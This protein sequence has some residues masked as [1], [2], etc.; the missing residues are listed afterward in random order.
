M[1]VINICQLVDESSAILD[2]VP[3]PTPLSRSHVTMNKFR[4]SEDEGYKIVA[5]EI[6]DILRKIRTNSPLEEV[7][8]WIRNESYTPK[9]LEIERLTGDSLLMDQCYTNL[10][11]VEQQLDGKSSWP[12][13]DKPAQRSSQFS[14]FAR[15]KIDEPDEKIQVVLSKLFDERQAHDGQMRRPKRVLIRGWA[16][17]GKTTL[18]KKIIHDFIGGKL[19][20][21][22]FDHLLWVPLRNLKRE[23]RQTAIYNLH[24]LVRHEYF[25]HHR[26]GD[27][28]AEAVCHASES[29]KTESLFILDGLDEELQVLSGS[30]LGFLEELLNQPNVI[31]TSRPHAR[32]PSSA[33]PVDLEL[34]TIGFY[35]DQISDYLQKAFTDLKAADEF[36]SFLKKHPLMQ[37]LV[38]IPIQLDALCYTWDS[39]SAKN[40]PQAM[41]AIYKAIEESLWKKDA[42]RLEKEID[43]K[44]VMPSD[45]ESAN[46]GPI[47][48][49]ELY[50]LEGLAFTGPYQDTIDFD[51]GSRNVI[52][53]QFR[54]SGA[55]ILLDK[56]FPCLSFLRTSEPS[57]KF[58]N[59]KYHFLH[60]T[61]QEYFAA[62]YF[63][64]QWM[65][66]EPLICLE[67]KSKRKKETGPAEFLQKYKYD[68][69]YDIFWR[70]A[71]GLIDAEG[72]EEA[73]RFF[74]AI[75]EEPR[76]L[77]GPTHQRLIMHC[78]GEMV[79]RESESISSHF[80][81]GLEDHLSQ[82][83]LF[84]CEFMRG[85]PLQLAGER[86]VPEQALLKALTLASNEARRG[87]L[88]SLEP[89]PVIEPSIIH[90]ARSW[91]RDGADKR[92]EITVL[93]FL[94]KKLDLDLEAVNTIA[95]RLEH[96]DVDVQQ[97]AIQVIQNQQ[98]LSLD[99]VNIITEQLKHEDE[100]TQQTA[101]EALQNQQNLSLD[102]VNAITE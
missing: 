62:R 94:S 63:V 30:M 90:L 49:K 64:K 91:L 18:C 93:N 8:A 79:P 86:E 101:V 56:T 77:L 14:L 74:Q 89:R 66:E 53:E 48:D 69:R 76:D 37:G 60:L 35:P 28:L 16:G 23:E 97:T 11:I 19:W 102:T 34:G 26:K 25:P 44:R 83:L 5:G 87:L 73:H 98:D 85:R 17:V 47:I 70:F 71:A 100:D 68:P 41:T 57:S 24:H 72:E 38:R 42:V 84:E 36:Q 81:S 75:E 31:V 20:R 67:I 50:L 1:L 2:I 46:M 80:R 40:V 12:Q 22:L 65:A 55:N 59:R 33:K 82:W 27:A 61:F 3:Y 54:L 7:D 95:G 4:S 29:P 39:F 43:G 52:S 99:I 58:D 78:L 10:A 21:D 9:R 6:R 45:I 92:I 51:S 13:E 32:F 88:E 96:E 15:L